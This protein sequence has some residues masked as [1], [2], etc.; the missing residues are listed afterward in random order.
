MALTFEDSVM[1]RG[2]IVVPNSGT[3]ID[4]KGFGIVDDSVIESDGAMAVGS[5][6]SIVTEGV[7]TPMV[8]SNPEDWMVCVPIK[9]ESVANS[10]LII[11]NISV[12]VILSIGC[13]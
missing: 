3:V 2:L 5:G 13:V 7:T 10:E 11:V 12:G 4:F 1:A 6:T 9:L 8:A